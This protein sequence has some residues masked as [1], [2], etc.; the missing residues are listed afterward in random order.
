MRGAE[1]VR[2]L[3][4][5]QHHIGLGIINI[6]RRV[7]A[8]QN[9]I[10]MRRI[11]DVCLSYK[12]LGLHC[13]KVH[14]G[15]ILRMKTV[16]LCES[17]VDLNYVVHYAIRKNHAFR[18]GNTRTTIHFCCQFA[19]EHGFPIN[20]QLF[21]GNSHYMCTALV[22][23]NAVFSDIGDKSQKQY[24]EMIIRDGIKNGK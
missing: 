3:M 21:E 4:N 11:V 14:H 5:Q 13:L 6:C 15:S 20:R 12:S 16:S 9:A 19:D 17:A 2:K 10:D 22:A 7:S 23:N 8:D 24:L 1:Y 18:E